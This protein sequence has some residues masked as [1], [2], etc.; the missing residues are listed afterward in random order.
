MDP[1]VVTL[2]QRSAAGIEVRTSNGDEMDPLRA[3][4]PALWGR[5][6]SEGLLEK[7]PG[8]TD[9]AV[10]MGIYSDYE[11]DHTG[12]YTLMAGAEVCTASNAAELPELPEGMTSLTVPAGRYLKFLA[13]GPMPQAL[14]ETWMTIWAYFGAESEHA[15]AFTTDF[16]LHRGPDEAE[17]YISIR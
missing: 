5:F 4:I 13:R 14:V 17:I 7:I 12:P 1:Q 3:R 9:G 6:F 11:T 8:R 16:E 15:R 10:P 2:E